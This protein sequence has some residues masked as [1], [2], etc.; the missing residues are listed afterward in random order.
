MI[1]GLLFDIEGTLVG[2]KRFIPTPGAL[3]LI[4]SLRARRFPIRLVTNNTT[5]TPEQ[6]LDELDRA[7][8]DFSPIEL[9]T[10]FDAALATLNDRGVRRCFVI[11]NN[12]LRS[13]LASHGFTV[14]DNTDVDAVVV[15]LDTEL[16]YDRL[17][18]ATSA[19]AR[20]DTLLIAM[21][22]NRLYRDAEGRLAPSVGAIATAIAYA[23][24]VEPLIVG[25]PSTDFYRRALAA[26]GLS[27]G[28]V[29]VVSDDPF[30]D[31]AGAKR[32]GLKAVL[33]L[34]GKYADPAVVNQLP[35]AERPD[36]VIQD[37]T[38]LDVERL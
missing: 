27:A 24:G 23:T 21:H 28:E 12:Q 18:T 9:V 30:S 36:L 14:C 3:A 4:A 32:L 29:A 8:F 2:D 10:C 19:V 15:G 16:T 13:A 17:R 25:K 33:V 26:I 31:L 7:G 38:E 20:G 5:N 35:P 22:L 11:G 34:V 1:S 6:L 37:L